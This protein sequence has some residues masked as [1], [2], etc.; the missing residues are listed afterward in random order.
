MIGVTRIYRIVGLFL[1]MAMISIIVQGSP[2]GETGDISP[3]SSRDPASS[4]EP[5]T[6]ENSN[7]LQITQVT[8]HTGDQYFPRVSDNWIVWIENES[9]GT[10][11]LYLYDIANRSERRIVDCSSFHTIPVIS[12][13]WI[14]WVEA[15]ND[16]SGQHLPCVCVYSISD[17]TTIQVTRYPAMPSQTS[18][19]QSSMFDLIST[20]DISGNGIVWH[21]R[22]NGNMDIYYANLTSGEEHQITSSPADQTSPSIS[23]DLIVW[24]EK[25]EGGYDN[26]HLYNLT[27]G[28]LKRITRDPAIRTDQVVSGEHVVWAQV[29]ADD[30]DICCYNISSGNT[31]W[32][33]S[34]LADQRWPKISGDLIVWSDNRSGG[35]TDVYTYDLSAQTETQVT[36]DSIDQLGADIDGS[37]IVWMENRTGHYAVTLC[38]QENVS[39]AKPRIYA[40]R[41][42]SIPQG[43]DIYVNREAQGRTPS[44][45]YFD[46]PGSRSIEFVKKGFKP[47]ATTLNVT[48]SMDYVVNLQHEGTTSRGPL[49]L[50]L[51]T[52]TVDSV[53]R[54]ANVS[55]DGAYLGDTLFNMDGLP[56]RDYTLEVTHEGYQPNST[57]VNSSE[58]VNV[59]LIPQ[60][61][62]ETDGDLLM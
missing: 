17:D 45:L 31:T 8:D 24:A 20:L 28:D 41:L 61:T 27:S 43:A 32:I 14:G 29:R 11:G 35:G 33:T 37:S 49:P 30:Y 40:V 22:R 15:R 1:F 7:G 6:G 19:S 57:T 51:M 39:N 46:Q 16:S 36:N 54:G 53:P 18:V 5:G 25:I 50:I 48:D 34:E 26:I 44:T 56:V 60:E 4:T 62:D 10:M 58:P 23:G 9:E 13:N 21:D 3:I 59:T 2:T 42:N 47:Y 55:I 52:I 38:S 12:G